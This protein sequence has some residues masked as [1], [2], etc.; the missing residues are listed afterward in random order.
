MDDFDKKSR[1]SS[2]RK[3]K[4]KVFEGARLNE[5]ELL[6]FEKKKEKPQNWLSKTAN[7]FAK[8]ELLGSVDSDGSVCMMSPGPETTALPNIFKKK[9]PEGA[10]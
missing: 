2:R 6:A 4:D 3:I 1:A 10:S 5:S 7:Q 9:Q 8:N